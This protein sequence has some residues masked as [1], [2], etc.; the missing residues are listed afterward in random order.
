MEA[1]VMSDGN[2]RTKSDVGII[3]QRYIITLLGNWDV[4]EVLSNQDR[5]KVD[6]PFVWE[7]KT[8]YRLK[9]R[10]DENGDGSGVV[11]VKAWKRGDP[12][13]EAWTLEAPIKHIHTHGAP[14]VYGFA[15]GNQFPV[16]IDNIVI[17]PN[18]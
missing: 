18:P 1:D 8:W 14:G 10:V 12:E 6:V 13:P 4:L 2:R 9:S 17:T 3:N 7:R 16:Y 5:V 15:L 11:R